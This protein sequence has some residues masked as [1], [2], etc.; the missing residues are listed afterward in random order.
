M[1]A[2]TPRTEA[3]KVARLERRDAETT[4]TIKALTVTIARMVEQDRKDIFIAR[5]VAHQVAAIEPILG[6]IVEVLEV[7]APGSIDL[8][9][10]LATAAAA[11][12]EQPNVSI[13]SQSV[14]REVSRIFADV[15]ARAKLRPPG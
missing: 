14:V 6:I 5:G 2:R 8:L 11:Q 12:A 3:E 13:E 7:Q 15:R 4:D 1:G 10:R 9:E